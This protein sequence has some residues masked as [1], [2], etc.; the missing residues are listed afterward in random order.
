MNRQYP[1]IPRIACTSAAYTLFSCALVY[2]CGCRPPK[3]ENM[4]HDFK[5]RPQM[6]R[7]IHTLD[8]TPAE[9]ALQ[10]RPTLDPNRPAPPQIELTLEQCRALAL[11]NNLDLKVQ[12]INPTIAAERIS[13]EEARFEAAL[14]S[15]FTYA[16]SDAPVATELDI[17]GP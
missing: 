4:L 11:E 12:L 10:N 9:P 7:E 15:R 2:F 16:K 8:L 17:A 3:A 1:K 5:T 14:R 13:E 6:I